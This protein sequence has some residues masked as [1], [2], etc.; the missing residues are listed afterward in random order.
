MVGKIVNER[1][2]EEKIAT[3]ATGN[4]EDFL[5]LSHQFSF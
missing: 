1:E 3:M 4:T 2:R 5:G